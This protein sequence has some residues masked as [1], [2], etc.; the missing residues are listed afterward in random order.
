MSMARRAFL[1]SAALFAM[2]RVLF[3]QAA[4]Q[5]RFIF[6]IQ[7]GAADGLH[8]VVPY[9]EPA[10]QSARGALAIDSSEALK[11]DG[12]FAL[13]P[14]LAEVHRMYGEGQATFFHAVAS[15]Y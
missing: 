13:H 2:P 4:T 8:T 7:R 15:P 12:T 9:A 3:A 1:G 6:I 14:S 5:R 11:L 10:Y